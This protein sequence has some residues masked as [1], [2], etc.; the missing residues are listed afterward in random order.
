[1]ARLL[2]KAVGAVMRPTDVGSFDEQ[3]ERPRFRV[4]MP[5]EPRREA[6]ELLNKALGAIARIPQLSGKIVA[7]LSLTDP[8]GVRRES[9]AIAPAAA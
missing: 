2:P 1:V 7:N 8:Q 5:M 3:Q 6:E 4:F 9:P